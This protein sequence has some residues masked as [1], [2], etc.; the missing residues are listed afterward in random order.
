MK[1]IET[2]YNGIL[3]RSRLE[4]RWAVLFDLLDIT[5]IYEP[6]CFILSNNQ[7]YTP[8]FYLPKHKTYVEVKPNEDWKKNKYHYERYN[9][10]NENILILDVPFPDLR[11]VFEM[12]DK[13]VKDYDFVHVC[14]MPEYSKYFPFFYS[15][16]EKHELDSLHS[17]DYEKEINKLKNHRFWN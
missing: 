15:G 8:D 10:F 7:K 16:N 6:E 3:F 1:A 17:A 5:Y 14:L 2:E 4:A 13:D 9:L 11:L 12:K